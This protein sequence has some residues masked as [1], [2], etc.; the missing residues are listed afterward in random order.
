MNFGMIVKLVRSL[1]SVAVLV[2]ALL[3]ASSVSASPF[4][5]GW[6]LDKEA[7][8]L[9]F[10]SV[11]NSSVVETSTFASYTGG[12]DPQG[13][14]RISI[15]L[16]S[17]DTKVDLRNVRM[18]FL[19]FETFKFPEAVITANIDPTTIADLSTKRRMQVPIA[20]VLDLHGV[21]QTMTAQ[22]VV[23]L[24]ADDMVSVASADPISIAVAPFGL[25]EGVRKL[26]DAAKVQIVPS[27]SVSFDFIFRLGVVETDQAQAAAT[28][29]PVT[30]AVENTGN[31]TAAECAG[32]FEILSRTGAI[33]FNSGSSELAIASAPF[34]G[35]IV[36]IVQR[37][38]ALNLIVEGHTDSS[39]AANLNQ[40][41][42]EKRANAVA[43]YLV[44]AGVARD[45]L[46]T[47]G[48][49]EA[50]PV[51]PNDTARN[52]ERNRRIQFTVAGQ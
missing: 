17:V 50:R 1:G 9:T 5:D 48:Y 44:D 16:D 33:Y 20:Y 49:G 43:R 51:A 15:S 31:F 8:R 12:I 47:I 46:T 35:S 10:Q 37:C 6:T 40:R 2:G 38:P 4:G 14:A 22:T 27:G 28:P 32:R 11:K 52:K 39:G 19:F 30:A 25:E 34:L 18:R 26:E 45:R 13:N 3:G 24:I 29:A 7:S 36:E 21:K 23:T 41:L 42:S